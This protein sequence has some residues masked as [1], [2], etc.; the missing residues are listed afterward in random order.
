MRLTEQ[1]SYGVEF[2]VM[3]V[4]PPRAG[5]MLVD[6]D[7][8]DPDC[9]SD[10]PWAFSVAFPRRFGLTEGQRVRFVACIEPQE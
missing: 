3:R 2:V 10:H 9:P 6:V 1:P 7:F 4:N 8:A 5:G